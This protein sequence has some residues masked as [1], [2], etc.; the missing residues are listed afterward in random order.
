MDVLGSARC[1]GLA[2]A[3]CPVVDACAPT[4]WLSRKMLKFRV[5]SPKSGCGLA[6]KAFRSPRH[7]SHGIMSTE[8][9]SQR[10]QPSG[11]KSRTLKDRDWEPFKRLIVDMHITHD[12][13]LD[14]VRQ[15]MK[16]THGFDAT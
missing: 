11:K 15:H 2:K 10:R 7:G 5:E 8:A 3:T 13:S 6:F 12:I 9:L 14:E 4:P 16:V 1:G